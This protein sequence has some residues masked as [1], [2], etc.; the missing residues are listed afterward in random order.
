MD[1]QLIIEIYNGKTNLTVLDLSDE[2]KN[3]LIKLC[4]ILISKGYKNPFL[5]KSFKMLAANNISILKRNFKLLQ[6]SVLTKQNSALTLTFGDRAENHAGMQIIGKMA[7]HGFTI[8]KLREAQRRLK[9][10]GCE[11]E[12]IDLKAELLKTWNN[13][14]N[15]DVSEAGVLLVRNAVNHI[16]QDVDF[17]DNDLFEEQINLN[18]D[19]KAFMYGR[20]V[21]KKARHN[22]CFDE[23]EQE[24]DYTQKKGR[25]VKYDNVPLTKYVRYSFTKY[26]GK[27]AYR[28]AGEGNYYYD[29]R[30]CG[31]GWHGDTERK[32]VVA[33]RLGAS[34]PLAYQWFYKNKVIGKTINLPKINHGDMYIMSEKASGFDW[35]KSSLPT[36]RH[37]AGSKN[38]LKIEPTWV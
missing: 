2:S 30:I 27:E 25:I 6:K 8:D 29:I 38:F 17:T 7:E 22:L 26:L 34:I 9:A 12:F 24:P 19:T 37:A 10:E 3:F 20:V 31:I 1:K 33:I 11:S 13:P 16:L 28:L 5:L 23:T 21:N 14:N 15:V 32:K 36:L 18:L 35:K 4:V